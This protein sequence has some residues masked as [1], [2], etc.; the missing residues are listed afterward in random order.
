MAH[1][2]FIATGETV[3]VGVT[4]FDLVDTVIGLTVVLMS[5][6]C[7]RCYSSNAFNDYQEGIFFTWA[8]L[9]FLVRNKFVYTICAN[10]VVLADAPIDNFLRSAS[11]SVILV[12]L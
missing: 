3:T 6:L 1:S 2:D 8:Y 12:A 7:G 4:A 11:T 9:S 5:T 10:I